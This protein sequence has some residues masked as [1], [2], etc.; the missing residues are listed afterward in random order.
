MNSM[1]RTLRKIPL[2]HQIAVGLII[3]ILI[4]VFLPGAVPVVGIFGDL[5]VR[6]LKGVAPLLVFILVMNAMVQRKEG[7]DT[8]MKPIITLYVI[9]TFAASIVGVVLSF[10]FPQTLMLQLG[11]AKVN[12]PSGIAEVVHNLVLNIVDNP[13]NAI[14]NANYIGI[15]AWAVIIGLAL[16]KAASPETKHV[17]ED[18]SAG[19]TK[20]VT[21]VI[22]FAPLGIM[23]LVTQSISASGLSALISY[24]SL[25]GVLLGS[26]FLVALVMNPIIVYLNVRKNPYPL[27]WATI[28]ESGIY[29]F[30]TRS[31]AANIPVNLTLCKRLGLNPDTY[32]ISIPLG[33]TINMAGASITISVLSL[34]A[35]HTLGV[36]VDLPTAL[37]LCIVSTVGACGAS[38]VAGGS[39]LLIPVACA[40]FGISND[41]A[42]QVVGV[43]FIISIIEDACE[44]ALNSSSDVLFT[45]TAEYARRARLGTLKAED[46]VPKELEED[47]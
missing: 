38:G 15:L 24:F 25:L 44:T 10:L 23:G 22:H 28:R 30:F 5:F 47:E 32:T 33:A 29:A 14:L 39:L 45:A 17:L 43:G 46:M 20:V 27:V 1:I 21:W 4:A 34:A 37:L 18:L 2:I 11:N 16:H 19:I 41:I 13:L 3:G 31:S 36:A 35:A 7:G 42:M 40:S 8:Q 9:G 26:Y 6:A 12:P